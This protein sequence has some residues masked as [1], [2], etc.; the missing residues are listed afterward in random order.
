MIMTRRAFFDANSAEQT[1]T[2]Q[3]AEKMKRPL[4]ILEDVIDGAGAGVLYGWT[5]VM[6]KEHRESLTPEN[7][8]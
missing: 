3:R 4:D 5:S 6:D 8:A 1:K 2:R 7:K